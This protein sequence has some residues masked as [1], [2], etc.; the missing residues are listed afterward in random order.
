MLTAWLTEDHAR[1]DALLK[2]SVADAQRFDADAFEQFRAGLLRH[3]AIEE[4]ILLPAVREKRGGKPLPIAGVL[5]VEHAALASLLVPT[6][7]HALAA[8]IAALLFQHNQKEEDATGL[9]AE[10]AALLGTDGDALFERARATAPPPLAKHFD[11]AGTFRSAREALEAAKRTAAR[12]R[13]R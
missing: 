12:R 10:C 2:A 3:I 7:D 1:L 11:G 8:E 13:S 4:K 6:P 5:R 9:Y